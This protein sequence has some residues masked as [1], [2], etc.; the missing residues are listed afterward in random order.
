M[1]QA[2]LI[3]LSALLVMLSVALIRSPQRD[4]LERAQENRLHVGKSL[5]G[6]DLAL[7]NVAKTQQEH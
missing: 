3:A 2:W 6:N 5:Y 1:P 4:G 7:V